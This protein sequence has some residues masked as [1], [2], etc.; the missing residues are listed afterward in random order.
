MKDKRS[1][2]ITH[3]YRWALGASLLLHGL[4][5]AY[6]GDWNILAAS[7]PL[8]KP[9]L[10]HKV[11]L[12]QQETPV[13]K[14]I[15]KPL[16][17]SH[18]TK[19]IQNPGK[20]PSKKIKKVKKVMASQHIT[21]AKQRK[22]VTSKLTPA[23]QPITHS[24]IRKTTTP[25]NPVPAKEVIIQQTFSQ[26]NSYQPKVKE[27]MRL[28]YLKPHTL[29]QEHKHG[30]HAA[31]RKV[32][33]HNQVISPQPAPTVTVF[34]QSTFSEA[35][36]KKVSLNS[37]NQITPTPIVQLP[38]VHEANTNPM[39]QKVAEDHVA[40]LN[41]S[42]NS[43][44]IDSKEDSG[45][46]EDSSE[47]VSG[48]GLSGPNLLKLKSNY[49]GQIRDRVARFKYYP[50]RALRRELEGKPVLLFKLGKEGQILD[51]K[52]S[53]S[54]GSPLLDQAALDSVKKAAPYPALPLALNKD[55][56]TIQL[57]VSYTLD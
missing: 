49:I 22:M 50:K 5:I 6:F 28:A 19:T 41:L 21:K 10:I 1:K 7:T 32:F 9:E 13:Q 27:R 33:I 29:L 40:A 48:E 42:T 3:F 12:V 45:V 46:Q 26:P 34:E 31:S 57:P 17:S 24:L 39:L 51:L 14:K 37:R 8:K 30:A 43:K 54:S 18:K 35:E 11:K 36:G 47:V 53:K 25:V 15:N 52:L 44:F 55:F 2:S 38:P 56:M 4:L 16:P 20:Q 23:G